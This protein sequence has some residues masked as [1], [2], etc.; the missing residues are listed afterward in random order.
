MN[1]CE[2]THEQLNVDV[3]GGGKEEGGKKICL[4]G[5]KYGK[6]SGAREH[7][8]FLVGNRVRRIPLDTPNAS[9]D[10][11]LLWH[12]NRYLGA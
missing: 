2:G 12:L 3:D 4:T 6:N 7:R 8:V 11:L 5:N 1:L 10:V 9:F